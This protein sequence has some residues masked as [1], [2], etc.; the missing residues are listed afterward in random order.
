[1]WFAS[2]QT[3]ILRGLVA[4]AFGVLLL[5][6]PAISLRVLIV[7]FGAFALV[8]GA[9]VLTTGIQ[10]PSTEPA[11][12][13]ALAAG[14]GAMAVGVLTFLWPGLTALALLVLIALRAVVIGI[15]EV[16]TAVHLGRDGSGPAL[17]AAVGLASI[18]FGIF[19][20]ASPGTALLALVWLI[21]LYAVVIGLVSIARAWVPVLSGA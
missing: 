5:V 7:L 21:G 15:A 19:L 10:T 14:V 11:R 9:L 6:W 1:M 12:Q 13:I 8:D 20:L 4:I 18:A 2:R 3:L 16:A 17:L